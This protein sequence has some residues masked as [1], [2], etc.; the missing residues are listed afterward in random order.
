MGRARALGAHGRWDLELWDRTGAVSSTVRVGQG[1]WMV[2]G[3]RVNGV[4]GMLIPCV[5]DKFVWM[6]VF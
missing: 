1:S 5:L 2:P 3:E 4:S 6:D